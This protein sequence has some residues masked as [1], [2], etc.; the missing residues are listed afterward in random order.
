M[1]LNIEGKLVVYVLVRI[2]GGKWGD[3][4][5]ISYRVFNTWSSAYEYVCRG[6]YLDGTEPEPIFE[7]EISAVDTAAHPYI[8]EIYARDVQSCSFDE[9]EREKLM[10]A[11]QRRL[12]FRQR[13][14]S[15][16]L[17]RLE[18]EEVQ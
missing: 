5:T 6:M 1:E 12:A 8:Y 13:R 10:P 3:G 4:S 14:I 16:R 18:R 15:D 17:A 9:A 7:Y 11:R 2:E